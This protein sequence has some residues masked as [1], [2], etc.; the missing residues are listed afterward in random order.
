ML[1][2]KGNYQLN[3]D[4]NVKPHF[5]GDTDAIRQKDRRMASVYIRDR[6]GY[7]S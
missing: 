4:Y 5:Q 6:S 3:K 7:L 1:K 2:I